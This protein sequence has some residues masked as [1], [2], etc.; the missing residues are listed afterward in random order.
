MNLLIQLVIFVVVFNRWWLF[1]RF[2]GKT[3]MFLADTLL[4]TVLAA[5]MLARPYPGLWSIL[6]Y[7]LA[8]LMAWIAFTAGRC[9]L[10]LL[11]KKKDDTAND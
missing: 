3:G 6:S 8:V 4:C 10:R 1:E 11:G 5:H 2:I 9:F 7:T